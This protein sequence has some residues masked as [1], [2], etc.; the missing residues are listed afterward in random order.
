V[1]EYESIPR[2][3]Y[4]EDRATFVPVC[5]TCG[6]FVKADEF[7]LTNEDFGLSKEP[8]ATCSKCGRTSMIFEGF[9]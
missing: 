8:N 3:V 2:K 1:N 5:I 6:R 7:V 4:G 9:L